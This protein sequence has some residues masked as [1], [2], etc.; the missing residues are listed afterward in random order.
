MTLYPAALC[1]RGRRCV[2]VG[3][4]PVAERKAG[5]LL[6]CEASV[7]LVSP[8]LTPV[9]ETWAAQGRICVE[10]R[11]FQADDLNGAM[12]AIA[13]TSDTAVNKAVMLAGRE[14]N[15]LVNVVDVPEWCDFYVP[16][17]VRRG[18]LLL[19]VNTDGQSPILSKQLRQQLEVQFGAEWASYLELLGRL[20]RALKHA[21][22]NRDLRNQAEA[23][24]LASPALSLLADGQDSEAASLLAAVLDKYAPGN[25]KEAC[26]R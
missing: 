1:V 22:P 6:E 3:G 5:A 8:E 2:V 25:A 16:A 24:F 18:D 4:G 14:R 10:R 12:I 23:E 17:V 19:T 26:E 15:V 11:N 9:L 20:R 7:F 21:Q 13:A